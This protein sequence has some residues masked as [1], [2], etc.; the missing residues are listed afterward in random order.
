MP[1]A[2]ERLNCELGLVYNGQTNGTWR[3]PEEVLP[4]L[5]LLASLDEPKGG[6]ANDRQV[7]RSDADR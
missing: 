7:D 2:I 4:E 1:C 3:D 6:S 5:R